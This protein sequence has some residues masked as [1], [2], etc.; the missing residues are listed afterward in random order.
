[1]AA[2]CTLHNIV[3][4]AGLPLPDG[5]EDDPHLPGAEDDGVNEPAAHD[6]VLHRNDVFEQ[7]NQRLRQQPGGN[8]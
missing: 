6:A 3:Q 7:F 5:E 1:M 2:A 8:G 4:R